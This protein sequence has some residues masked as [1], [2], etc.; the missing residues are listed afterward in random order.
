VAYQD[1]ADYLQSTSA[2][3]Y[4]GIIN[5][6]TDAVAGLPVKGDISEGRATKGAAQALLANV[7]LTIGSYTEAAA[8]LNAVITDG[9][10]SLEPAF[11][12]V[13]YQERNDEILFAVEYLDDSNNNSEDY[14]R[15]FTSDGTASGVNTPTDD[16][17]IGLFG[18]A[19]SATF[20]D[21]GND[22][23]RFATTITT[24][25]K[26]N[27]SVGKFVSS[28][29]SSLLSG[30][31]WIILRYADVLLMY[32]EAILAGGT[33]TDDASAVAAYKEVLARAGH[34]VTG[35][36]SF[37][38][39]EL[40]EQRR[41]EFAFENKRWFDLERFGVLESTMIAF[42][43]GDGGFTFT[44]NDLILPIPDAEIKA[45]NVLVQNEGYN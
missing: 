9:M 3:V 4:D 26:K 11:R 33:S 31:D 7:Y 35:I 18:A 38:A 21:G 23:I 34:D 29:G 6:L 14:S 45:S 44:A 10:Y 36:T 15:E 40:L 24:D 13:F 5:D 20:A 19:D 30:N 32:A 8:L 16:L 22:P 25:A 17:V 43:A 2:E 27:I 39:T 42:G 12:D 1:A 37:T 28:S 41:R